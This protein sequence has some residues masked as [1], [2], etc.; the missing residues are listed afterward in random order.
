MSEQV[1]GPSAADV[2]GFVT[3][4]RL[5]G[6][7]DLTLQPLGGGVSSDVWR[8]SDGSRQ[9]VVKTPLA[10]LRVAAGWKAPVAR[11]DAEAGWLATVSSLVPGA[12]PEVLA[13][14]KERHLLALEYLDPSEHAL[15][16]GKLLAGQVD[17]R[18][19]ARVGDLLGRIHR[20]TS[21]RPRLARDFANDTLFAALRIEPYLQRLVT[22]H[23]DLA[24][25]VGEI[26]QSLRSHRSVLVHGDV[27]PK[28]ILIGPRGPVLIDAETAVWGDPSFDVAFCVNHLLLKCLLPDAAVTDLVGSAEALTRTYLSHASWEL[29]A[30]IAER[31][32]ALLPALMLAR[33]DGRSPVEYLDATAQDAVRRFAIP[34]IRHRSLDLL[35]VFDAWRSHLS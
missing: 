24:P 23:A 27:S 35:G 18:D 10:E 9:V 14:D 15:W 1:R 30:E 19:A 29:D 34:L 3:A 17:Q 7:E 20:H 5:L 12:C 28:N 8:V 22:T 13:Y 16:K 11:A 33:V 21:E 26:V 2:V 25:H 6:G 4:Q 32:G 31:A